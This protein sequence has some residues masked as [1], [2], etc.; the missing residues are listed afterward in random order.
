MQ[1]RFILCLQNHLVLPY[2]PFLEGW[3]IALEKIL[4]IDQ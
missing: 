3:E 1:I 4:V 2:V